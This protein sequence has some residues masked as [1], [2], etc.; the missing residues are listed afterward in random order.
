MDQLERRHYPKDRDGGKN[1]WK[2]LVKHYEEFDT[3]VSL[4]E[5]YAKSVV[6]ENMR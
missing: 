2:A 1:E 5:R 6:Q 4:M 3:K